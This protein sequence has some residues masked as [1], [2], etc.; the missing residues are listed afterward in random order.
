[1]LVL[2]AAG[3]ADP[4][5]HPRRFFLSLAPSSI[6]CSVEAT[7]RLQYAKP[8]PFTR[9]RTSAFIMI[10]QETSHCGMRMNPSRLLLLHEAVQQESTET[11]SLL[12][13]QQHHMQTALRLLTPLLQTQ[14]SSHATTRT[15]RHRPLDATF[16]VGGPLALQ[17][18]SP[19]FL[20]LPFPLLLIPSRTRTPIVVLWLGC[21]RLFRPLMLHL[22][23]FSLYFLRCLGFRFSFRLLIS[24]VLCFILRLLLGL[25]LGLLLC[26]SFS[27]LLRLSL[28]LLLC[29]SLDLL[30][31]LSLS[32]LLGLLLC[33]SLGLL[34]C[35]FL[36]FSL[37]LCLFR[38]LGLKRTT[39]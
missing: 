39:A 12:N 36:C 7:P 6:P 8:H 3:A 21:R 10:S 29:L 9:A 30:L 23:L 16:L 33:L 26:S 15:C 1:M 20:L 27:L 34:L 2:S 11:R 38:F 14:R 18:L 24:H 5:P 13:K 17:Q 19:E 22:L 35:L 28:G 37:S 25:G 32:L 4:L 31:C